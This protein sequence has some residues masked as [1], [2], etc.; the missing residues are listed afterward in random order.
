M[1]LFAESVE[2]H[3][4]IQSKHFDS[5]HFY[6]INKF[7]EYNH[8]YFCPPK[9]PDDYSFDIGN[10][11]EFVEDVDPRSPI[12]LVKFLKRSKAP[13]L[14]SIQ[15]EVRRLGTTTSL[16]HHLAKLFTSSISPG[17]IP[18]TWKISTSD[19][20]ISKIQGLQNK[21]IRLALHLPECI[22][23]KLLHDSSVLRYV[24]DRLLSCA[25]QSLDRIAQNPLVE[26]SISSNRLNPGWDCFPMPLSV[27]CPVSLQL[28]MN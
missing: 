1:Q 16:F 24:K 22:C 10:E 5:N 26:E 6:E 14:D 18:T 4:G 8:R 27:V 17:Y 2:S 7:I 13:G 15:N 19:Y 12:K 25:S 9:D 23:S 3:F 20:I 11:H 28:N 21:F